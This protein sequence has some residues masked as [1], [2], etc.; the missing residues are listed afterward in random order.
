MALPPL[1]DALSLRSVF[2]IFYLPSLSSPS[3]SFSFP[4]SES[5]LH[6][7]KK[8][9]VFIVDVHST[10]LTLFRPPYCVVV[11]CAL[12]LR[13]LCCAVF[14]ISTHHTADQESVYSEGQLVELRQEFLQNC[15]GFFPKLWC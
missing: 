7:D 4:L 11:F 2:H 9:G 8:R 13:L 15:S 10:H 5:V 3:G 1:S 6:G 12:P 14:V